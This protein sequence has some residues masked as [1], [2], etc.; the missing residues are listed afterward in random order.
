MKKIYLVL[1]LIVAVA[2]SCKKPTTVQVINNHPHSTGYQ[3]ADGTLYDVT[4]ITYQ[5]QNKVGQINLGFIGYG[6][7]KS[8]IIELEDY[9]EKIR[10]VYKSLSN[11]APINPDL[12]TYDYFYMTSNKDN[13]IVLDQSVD[14]SPY[15]QK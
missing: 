9:V 11:E 15:P 14:V 13:V 1:V 5:G 10:V 6:G 2:T 12:Y 4:L 7:C 8:E 3:Y